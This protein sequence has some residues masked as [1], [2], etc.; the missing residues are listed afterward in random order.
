[1]AIRQCSA[2]EIVMGDPS[3]TL[4]YGVWLVGA[5]LLFYT[6]GATAA[7]PKRVLL[8]HSFG[9]DFAPFSEMT[10]SFHAALVKRSPEPLD[11][12]E[13]SIFRHGSGARERR[14]AG[15]ISAR[16]FF[17]GATLI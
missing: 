17:P 13:A 10:K 3:R 8:L 5:F 4:L 16:I 11:F 9:R 7:D 12:Y 6:L 2:P 15:R 14:F 1:M